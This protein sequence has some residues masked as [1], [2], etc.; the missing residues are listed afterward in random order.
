[1]LQSVRPL[2]LNVEELLLGKRLRVDLVAGAWISRNSLLGAA[3][4]SAM[5]YTN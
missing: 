1:V 2:V 3:P 5:F 4:S